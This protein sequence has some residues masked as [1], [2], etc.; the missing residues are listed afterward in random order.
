[1]GRRGTAVTVVSE[2]DVAFFDAIRDHVG[3]ENLEEMELV[4][5][6][7]HDVASAG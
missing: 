4:L 5:Y 2:W 6:S 7:R 1:M 3:A